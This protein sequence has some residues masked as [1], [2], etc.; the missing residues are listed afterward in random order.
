[1]LVFSGN[2]GVYSK[3]Q[4]IALWLI[5]A[6]LFPCSSVFCADK[7]LPQNLTAILQRNVLFAPLEV[8][9]DD[10]SKLSMFVAPI[11]PPQRLD[12]QY[13]LIGTFVFFDEPSKTT[14]VLKENASGRILFLKTGDIVNGNKIVS[15]EET[16]VVF[17][18]GFNEKFILTQSGIKAIHTQPQRVYF[19]VNLKNA[20]QWLTLQPEFLY[21]I[22][23]TPFD[24][25]GFKIQDIEPGSI[26]ESAGFT[27]NDVILQIN[28]II[29]RSPADALKAYNEIFKT[30]KKYAVIRVIRDRKPV[31]LVYFLE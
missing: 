24:S 26:F 5:L 21:G 20:M 1:M 18:N 12:A 22:K 30:G 29:L 4:N 14:A 17:E 23:L 25:A 15:I 27:S 11:S 16:G 28:D 6:C 7:K 13:L 3:Y 31:E 19:K 9:K 2:T 10:Q 8:K